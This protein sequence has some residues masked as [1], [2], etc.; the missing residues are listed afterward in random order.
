[1]CTL[2]GVR[3]HGAA[4]IVLMSLAAACSGPGS[5]TPP[6]GLTGVV[7]R[8]PIT[9]VCQSGVPCD[10]PFS[11][12]FTVERDGQAVAQFRSDGSGAF[13]VRLSPGTYSVTPDA[14]APLLAPKSQAKTVEVGP[15]GLT[16]VRLE[17]D[18]GIR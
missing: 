5:P 7:V 18:T 8:G 17:F 14:D 11:A 15:V 9:P 3:C 1:L 6:T 13:T 2:K 10:A 12:G 16:T 4:A